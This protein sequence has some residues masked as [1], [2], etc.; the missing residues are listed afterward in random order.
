MQKHTV[1]VAGDVAIDWLEHRVPPIDNPDRSNWRGYP[2]SRFIALQ[3]GAFLMARMLEAALQLLPKEKIDTKVVK[4]LPPKTLES[5]PPSK[6]IHS[7]GKIAPYPLSADDRR[8]QELRF[9]VERLDGFS[10]PDSGIVSYDPI[11]DDVPDPSIVLLGD[12]GNGFRESRNAWPSAVTKPRGNPWIVYKVN[13]PLVSGGLWEQVSKLHRE[14]TILVV[15]ADDLR[16]RGAQISRRLSWECTA[17]DCLWQLA[18]NPSLVAFQE[19]PHLVI[20]FD[21]DGAIYVRATKGEMAGTLFYDAHGIESGFRD[22]CSGQMV[23]VGCAFTAALTARLTESLFDSTPEKTREGIAAGIRDGIA[24]G[25]RLWRLGFG[26]VTGKDEHPAVDYPVTT[27]FQ[28]NDKLKIGPPISDIDLPAISKSKPVQ[29]RSWCILEDLNRLRGIFLERM[30]HDIVVNGFKSLDDVPVARFGD[31]RT[32]DRVEIESY[33]SIENLITNF[34]GNSKTVRPLCIAVFGPP[35]AGKSFGVKAVAKYV[36]RDKIKSIE[37]NVSQF[38]G[39]DDLAK[40]FHCVRDEVLNGKTPLVFFDEFD[41]MFQGQRLGWLKYFLGP[42]QDGKFKD[43][44]TE[45]PLGKAIFVFAGGTSKTFA[46]FCCASDPTDPVKSV[47]CDPE[48]FRNAKGRDFVSRLRGYV[49]V[50]GPNKVGGRYPEDVYFP[51]RRAVLLRSLLERNAKHLIDSEDK[52]RIDSGVLAAMIG[53]SEYKHGARSMEAILDM[54]RLTGRKE[55]E[56]SALPPADQLEAHVN[57]DEFTN[58]VLQEVLFGSVRE[59]LA[60]LLHEDYLRSVKGTPK[61]KQDSARPWKE[62]NEEYKDSN[63]KAAEH[64]RV[65]LQS[66]GYGYR[67]VPKGTA[68]PIKFPTPILN[69]LAQTEHD[70]FCRERIAKGW[71][72]GPTRDD[73]KKTNPTLKPWDQLSRKEKDLDRAQ[74]RAIPELMAR[75]GFQVFP[76]SGQSMRVAIA[77]VQLRR[78]ARS[79]KKSNTRKRT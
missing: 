19:W 57:A 20:R 75:V 53:V 36:A 32:L 14:R 42:M 79:N 47:V 61:A 67:P 7:I 16:Q 78:D 50:L 54:S 65:K 37:F 45:H 66:A 10:G 74:V 21:L 31:L 18:Y 44:E 29:L 62:L 38:N 13:H 76:L 63:R 2:G 25:R 1:V 73:K 11:S 64:I 33:R 6:I 22:R 27:I 48:T 28:D 26:E 40:A 55:F 4:Q 68:T 3:G 59:E 41:S 43:G 70:R 69:T 51:L 8:K 56:Q 52:A 58:L 39:V 15:D 30:A 72:H 49:N 34:M 77:A 35:G 5:V 9:R 46:D 60:K 71:Q 24:A 23:G 17:I 12:A